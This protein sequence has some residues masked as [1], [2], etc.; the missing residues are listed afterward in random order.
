VLVDFL[1]ETASS[2]RRTCSW[3]RRTRSWSPRLWP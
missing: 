2:Q 3:P 1:G